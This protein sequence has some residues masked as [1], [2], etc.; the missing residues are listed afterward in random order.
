[1]QNSGL[2]TLF[3]VAFDVMCYQASA[4]EEES[5]GLV[6]LAVPSA[7]SLRLRELDFNYLGMDEMDTFRA[8]IRMFVDFGLLARFSIDYNTLCKWLMTVKKNYRNDTV[9]YH[10]WW[11]AFN[12]CQT[13]FAMLR[14]SGWHEQFSK[15]DLLGLLVACLSHDL[16]HRG[17]T[18]SFQAK[19]KNPLATLYASSTLERHHLNQC[20]LLLNLPGNRILQNLTEEDY[21]AVLSVIERSILATDLAVHFRH[22]P[23]IKALAAKGRG[24][25]SSLDDLHTLQSLLMTAADLG[26]ATKPWE[27]HFRVSQLVAEEF[28]AQGDEEKER[29][30]ESPPPMMDREASLALV[31][32]EFLDGIC[33]D[34]YR[35]LASLSPALS[36]M[37]DA[38]EENRRRWGEVEG[39]RDGREG[40]NGL[41]SRGRNL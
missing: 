4:S 30:G 14:Q 41:P 25:K 29:F 28:W 26:A 31:Q 18:N 35:S 24:W 23:K 2:F 33:G 1:V 34:V 12:V 13:M 10:N 6:S 39:G 38:A 36:S 27:V 5:R 15:T 9:K 8:C 16:D 20:L 21:A 22:L 19:S 37:A 17:T 40:P 7:V 11:H 32:I 3:A